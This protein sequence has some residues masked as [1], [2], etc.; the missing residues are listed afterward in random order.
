M[1]AIR[2]THYYL[3][4][5]IPGTVPLAA[6]A[7]IENAR[8]PSERARCMR[9]A[10]LA[11]FAVCTSLLLEVHLRQRLDAMS[12]RLER[13]YGGDFEPIAVFEW[14]DARHFELCCSVISW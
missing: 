13:A 9:I 2:H 11:R 14:C 1:C 6:V 3:K 10:I 12:L 5:D 7:A 4:P 8:L